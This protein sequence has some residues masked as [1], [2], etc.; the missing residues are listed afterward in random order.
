MPATALLLI[1]S[2]FSK[3]GAGAGANNT[4]YNT[5]LLNPQHYLIS[6]QISLKNVGTTT[7]CSDSD[8]MLAVEQRFLFSSHAPTGPFHESLV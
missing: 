2:C 6:W 7:W 8:Q 5:V 1:F 4:E 3:V